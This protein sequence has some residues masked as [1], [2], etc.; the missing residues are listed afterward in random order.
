MGNYCM[1]VADSDDAA[2]KKYEAT[3]F[4]NLG[5]RKSMLAA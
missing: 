4:T 2:C 1:W 5:M 3:P